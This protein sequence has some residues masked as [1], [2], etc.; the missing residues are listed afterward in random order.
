MRAPDPSAA[1]IHQPRIRAPPR[2]GVGLLKSLLPVPYLDLSHSEP[3]TEGAAKMPI[4]MGWSE[5]PLCPDRNRWFR[6]FFREQLRGAKESMRQ[7]PPWPLSFRTEGE[8]SAPP[9]HPFWVRKMWKVWAG[10][11][12]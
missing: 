4:P 6:L 9:S 5:K 1:G 12:E 3:S 8:V 11:Q 10:D 2:Q 7:R